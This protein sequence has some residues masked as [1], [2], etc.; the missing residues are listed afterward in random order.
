MFFFRFITFA[1]IFILVSCTSNNSNQKYKSNNNPFYGGI[2]KIG[3][4][5]LIDNKIYYPK[6]E[7]EYDEIGIASWYGKKIPWKT[8]S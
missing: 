3:D 2:Y 4:P 8:H 5:Y 1:L 7:K 6:E